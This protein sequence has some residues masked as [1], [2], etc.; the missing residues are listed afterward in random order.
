MWTVMAGMQPDMATYRC[1]FEHALLMDLLLQILIYS[2]RLQ[3][4]VTLSKMVLCCGS[5]LFL[6]FIISAVAK[7]DCVWQTQAVLYNQ[8]FSVLPDIVMSQGL[9]LLVTLLG[10]SAL[11]LEVRPTTRTCAT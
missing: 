10:C 7:S 5:A 4:L 8:V 11:L 1:C 6:A 2:D 3:A 9:G